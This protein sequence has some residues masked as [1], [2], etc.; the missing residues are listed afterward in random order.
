M[1]EPNPPTPPKE[2]STEVRVAMI[3]AVAMVAVAVVTGIFS[4]AQSGG[5]RKEPPPA[6][7]AAV[8]TPAPTSPSAASTPVTP[9]A[10]APSVEIDG[11]VVAPLGERTY[12]TIISQNA[13]RAVWS[14]GGFGD[15]EPFEV[16]RLAPSHQIFVE[17]TDSTRVGDRFTIVVTVYNAGSQPAIA[18]H[19]FQVTD[20]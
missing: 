2:R 8:S 16:D 9:A 19:E 13:V 7:A 17:P 14:V 10:P 15:N 4:L 18:Q 11:P 20:K 3:G 5:A 6:P 1:S 12:F